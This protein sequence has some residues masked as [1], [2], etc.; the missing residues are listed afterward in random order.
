MKLIKQRRVLAIEINNNLKF[1][2]KFILIDKIDRAKSY[3]SSLNQYR[4]PLEKLQL[5]IRAYYE[6]SNYVEKENNVN[7]I[8]GTIFSKNRKFQYY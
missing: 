5:L 2:V 3:I 7:D 4:T 1:I 8:K 6:I